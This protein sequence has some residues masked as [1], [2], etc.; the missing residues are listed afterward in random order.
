MQHTNQTI[1]FKTWP[2]T[3]FNVWECDKL[4]GIP[5][6]ILTKAAS[7]APRFHQKNL[8]NQSTE[9][10]LNP[11]S[12]PHFGCVWD[13]LV[14]IVKR[15]LLINLGAAKL[16]PNVFSTNF[17]DAESLVNSRP[18]THVRSYNKDEDPL[19]PN[20][21]LLGRPFANT[22]LLPTLLLQ[23]SARLKTTSWTQVKRRLQQILKRLLL[24]YV[25]TY[26]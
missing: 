17:T 11:P 13:R 12:A 15:V 1:Y 25:P 19:T 5:Y 14:Q 2:A 9:W 18:L 21:F 22:S 24:E 16:T 23:E 7:F 26:I 6:A 20:H 4:F 8:L 3:S 10:R